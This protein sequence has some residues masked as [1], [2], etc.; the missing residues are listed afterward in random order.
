MRQLVIILFLVF[1]L[2]S[3]LNSQTT[4]TMFWNEKIINLGN[5]V[6]TTQPSSE[7]KVVNLGGTIDDF[8][9]MPEVISDFKPREKQKKEKTVQ[10]LFNESTS[11]NGLEPENNGIRTRKRVRA[12]TYDELD[13]MGRIDHENPRENNSFYVYSLSFI[14]LSFFLYYFRSSIRRGLIILLSKFIYTTSKSNELKN[15][16]K[17]ENLTLK[18]KLSALKDL[19]NL[20]SK[21]VINE[22]EF[23][24]LKLEIFN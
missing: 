20:Y 1:G 21:G 2:I 4:D 11:L 6:N 19:E 10:E 13:K 3:N 12:Y 16:G 23:N 14:I 7:P 5:G 9:K 22:V 18:D 17:K 15:N 8:R 24:R